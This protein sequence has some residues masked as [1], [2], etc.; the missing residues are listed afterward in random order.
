LLSIRSFLQ[1]FWRGIGAVGLGAD[2]HLLEKVEDG[3]GIP[4]GGVLI[5]ASYRPIAWSDGDALLH[6]LIDAILSAIGFEG[7]IG[8]L[9]PPGSE[10]IRGASSVHLLKKILQVAR[11]SPCQMSS[12][13]FTEV[14]LSPYREKILASLREITECNRVAVTF[15]SLEGMR[16]DIYGAITVV[17]I[18]G[19]ADVGGKGL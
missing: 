15:K 17:A 4:V 19:G 12:V 3:G 1:R 6:S 8:T 18:T 10:E 2:F 5:D 7:D 14:R 13:V 16:Y 9:Y 11:I